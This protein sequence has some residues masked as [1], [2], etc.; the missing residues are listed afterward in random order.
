M[1]YFF[2]HWQSGDP[3]KFVCYLIAGLLAWSLKVGLPGVE[4]T[5]SVNFL[6]TLIG[7]LE[8]T[9]PETPVQSNSQAGERIGRLGAE[10]NGRDP[11]GQRRAK[12]TLATIP[13]VTTSASWTLC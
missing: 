10:R 8:L 13:I 1:V 4:A 11:P 7:M 5:L 2:A 9:L 3:V 6:F 12:A